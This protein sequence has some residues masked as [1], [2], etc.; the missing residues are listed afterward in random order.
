M[1]KK[2]AIAASIG[3][4]LA[5]SAVLAGS[6]TDVSCDNNTITIDFDEDITVSSVNIT[7]ISV[8]SSAS[9]GFDSLTDSS[10]IISGNGDT[11]EISI[12]ASDMS[13]NVSAGFAGTCY[14]KIASGG[15]D[16]ITS[17]QTVNE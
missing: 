9:G 5:A 11:L 10:D 6:A 3:M 8:G 14:V 2:S 7:D 13:G 1:V 17:D 4:A 16:I 15:V 12:S